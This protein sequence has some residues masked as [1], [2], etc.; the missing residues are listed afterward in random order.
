M[1]TT[2]TFPAVASVIP[3]FASIRAAVTVARTDG[4]ASNPLGTS[5]LRI[6]FPL[7]FISRIRVA[8]GSRISPCTPIPRRASMRMSASANSRSL[9]AGPSTTSTSVPR[10]SRLDRASG[11][12]TSFAVFARR[13]VTRA[14]S[15]RWRAAT[16]PSPPLF[17]VPHATTIRFPRTWNSERATSAT[18]RPAASMRLRIETP[19]YSA[20]RSIT[21]CSAAVSTRPH[22]AVSLQGLRAAG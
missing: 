15:L 4:V 5:T 6:G 8:Y 20:L 18:P 2:R 17:P 12:A 13:T 10:R 21:R 19:K 16:R 7:L 11:V 3:S 9:C 14:S 1:S 22:P